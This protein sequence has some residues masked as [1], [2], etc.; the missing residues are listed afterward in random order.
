MQR[1][2]M[3]LLCPGD[4]QSIFKHLMFCG[5]NHSNPLVQRNMTIGWTIVGIYSESTAGNVK[6]P[7]R[8][9][10]IQWILVS[11]ADISTE[12]I[13]KSFPCCGLNL[14]IDGSDDNKIVCF[15]NDQPCSKAEKCL[16]LRHPCCS[17]LM[18]IH[19]K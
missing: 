8:R 1:R 15:Q 13:K 5:I 9:A 6:S 16:R 18:M 4:A 11:W 7:P 14:P 12:L 3:Q 17:N 10:V 19:S 2:S